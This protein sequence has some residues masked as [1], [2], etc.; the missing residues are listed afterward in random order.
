MSARCRLCDGA[1]ATRF[2]VD[3]YDIA[4]CPRCDL[5][6][7]WPTP[8]PSA[9]RAVYDDGY[10][11]AGRFGY[12]DYFGREREV[13]H[14]KA[15]ARLE[16]LASLG[17]R[18]GRVLDVGCAAGYFLEVAQAQGWSVEGVECS[19]E[20]RAHA[21]SSVRAHIREDADGLRG[22]YDVITF[23]DV[24]E[25]LDDE[26]PALEVARHLLAPGGIF[27]ATVP[28]F[29]MLWGPSD[30]FNHHRRRY[31]RDTLG[32]AVSQVFRVER[33]SY[34]N[35]ALFPAVAVA[36]ALSRRL[37]RPG[38]EEIA[39]PPA[40]VNAALTR[41]FRAERHLLARADLPFG[42]SLLCVARRVD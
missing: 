12:D 7:V 34:F 10:F 30:T 42:V 31:T 9:V 1:C 32:A 25:H 35:A 23:W 26:R 14:R 33:M 20:A 28:A 4:R 37:N 15:H 19:A 11:T 40:P 18:G 2:T 24:L 3:G 6:F 22:P 8:P 5:E 27:L 36:R 38:A 17:H 16:R 39:L 29:P 41:L 21:P 13:A